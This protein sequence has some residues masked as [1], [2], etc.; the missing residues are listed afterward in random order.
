MALYPIQIYK[1]TVTNVNPS[2]VKFMMY[3][4]DLSRFQSMVPHVSADINVAEFGNCQ[5]L[6]AIEEKVSLRD[7]WL[8]GRLVRVV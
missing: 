1:F 5:H 8:V 6:G 4:H 7:P 2:Y 3:W